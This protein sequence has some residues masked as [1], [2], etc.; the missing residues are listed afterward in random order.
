VRAT[1][2]PDRLSRLRTLLAEQSIDAL[3][4]S[5]PENRAYL[6]GFTGSAGVLF[7]SAELALVATDFRYYEQLAIESPS[8][9]LVK[10]TSTFV[11]VLPELLAR[12]PAC[13]NGISA[14]KRL[15]FES[16]HVT[17]AE[18]QEWMGA[19]PDAEWVPT[20]G[21]VMEMRAIKDADEIQMLSEAIRL[22][23]EALAVSVAQVWLGMTERQLA[24]LIESHIRTHGAPAVSF[25]V[26]VAAGPN[27]ARPHAR[28]SD[29]VLPEGEPIVIDMG[30]RL[31][32]Y[33]AD[34]TRTICLGEPREPDRFWA[35][36]N[37]VL[38]AQQAAEAAIRPG[39]TGQEVDAV[40]REMISE[41]GYGELFGHGLGHGVGLAV[42]E[43]PRLSRL[44]TAPLVSGNV[45][46]VEPGIYLSGW[47]GVRIEDVVLVT[48]SGVEVLT[49]APK[50]PIV[51]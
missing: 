18:A 50:D 7:V 31:G 47:G 49:K 38:R 10:V 5:Q 14:M 12:Q 25:D 33:C 8:F 51:S 17:V 23:D 43:M 3:L 13:C 9:E 1:T 2:I 37:T 26:V 32:G 48:E 42:H 15:G 21:L 16:D 44:A 46:T 24:W 19:A 45:V 29:T 36:Y 39:L 30:A 34:L 27:G 6:S 4:V 22:T 11:D 35:I 28:A 20:K 41:A 40:A